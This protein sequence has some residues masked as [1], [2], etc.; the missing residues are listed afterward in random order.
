MSYLTEKAVCSPETRDVPVDVDRLLVLEPLQHGVDDDEGPGAAHPGRAVGDDR[1]GVHRVHG[2]DPAEELQ[3]GRRV[4]RDAVVGPRSVLEL[5]D[6]P[7]VGE[8][9]LDEEGRGRDT[10]LV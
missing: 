5:A 10:I 4:L 8:A 1:A 7:P 3:E 9:H 2:V 6:L